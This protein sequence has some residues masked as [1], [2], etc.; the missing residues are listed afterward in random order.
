MKFTH[1][2]FHLDKDINRN[3]L[4]LSMNQYMNNYS[5]E[6]DSPTISI[7]NQEELNSFYASNPTIKFYNDGYEFN[8]EIGW[9]YGELGIWASNITAYK[10]FLKSDSDYLILMEDDIV[11]KDGFFSN[12]VNYLNQLPE[13]WDVFFYYAPQNKIP[14]EI[15]SDDKDVCRAYQDWSCLCY[16]IN[17]VTAKIVVDDVSNNQISLPIDYYFLKQNKYNCYTVKP[18]SKFYCEIADI[19]STFQT[20]QQRKVLA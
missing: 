11:Y 15:Y 7:S 6:L 8:N 19:E 4:Y 16:I 10:N 5:Q 13:N 2:I 1:K 14:S 9:R 20:K 12:L 17:R 3:H 18:N